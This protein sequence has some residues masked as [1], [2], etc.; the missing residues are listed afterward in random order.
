M[1]AT[2]AL[3]AFTTLQREMEVHILTNHINPIASCRHNQSYN[4]AVNMFKTPV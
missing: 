2:L 4:H 1:M 3:G